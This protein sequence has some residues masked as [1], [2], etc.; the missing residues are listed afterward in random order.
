MPGGTAIAGHERFKLV[1]RCS[2][3]FALTIALQQTASA[4]ELTEVSCLVPVNAPFGFVS[5]MQDFPSGEILIGGQS[6]LFLG[7]EVN[8]KLTVVPIGNVIMGGLPIPVPNMTGTVF[9]M[10]GVPGGAILIRARAGL[11]LARDTG[12]N[13]TVLP[14]TGSGNDINDLF[15]A[16][17]FPGGGLLIATGH[18]SLTTANKLFL[19]HEVSGELTVVP[20]SGAETGLVRDMRDF[21]G[22]RV[23]IAADNGLFLAGETNGKFTLARAGNVDTGYVAAMHSFS[24]GAVLIQAAKGLFLTRET[25]GKLTVTPAGSVSTGDVDKI[26][27]FSADEAL[28]VAAE[29]FFLVRETNGETTFMHDADADIARG[30]QMHR[31]PGGGVLIQA[32]DDW[33]LAREAGGKFTVTTATGAQTGLVNAMHDFPDGG[34]LIQAEGKWFLARE[35]NDKLTIVPASGVQ[36]DRVSEMQDFPGG[37][38]L[39]GTDNGLFL[40]R[41]TNGNL[42]VATAGDKNI[43]NVRA[44]HD[45][46]GGRVLIASSR[47]LSLTDSTPLSKATVEIRDRRSLNESLIEPKR[48]L[49]LDFTIAHSCAP[50]IDQLGL[51]VRVVAPGGNPP[52]VYAERVER[53]T[54]GDASAEIA[55]TSHFDKPGQWA[56]QVVAQ[57]GGGER[58]VGEPQTLTFVSGSW[59]ERWWKVS[60]AGLGVILASLN[61]LL[62][63]LARRSAWAWRLATDDAWGTRILRV[64]TLV[65]SHVPIAQLWIIDLY[66]QR[67]RARLR[68]PRPFLPLP[69]TAPDGSLQNSAEASSPPWKGR[70]LWVQGGSGMGKTSLFRDVT[71]SHFREHKTAF[72]AY[73]KWGCVLVAFAARDFATSGEDKDDPAWVVDAVRATLSSEGLTFASQTLLSR[74]LESGTLAVAID[75]LNEVDRTRAVEAFARA[76]SEAP[77]LITSQQPGNE[78]FTTWRLPTDFRDFTADLLRLYL[79]AEQTEV[80][81][82]RITTS[83]LRDAIR[84]GYDVRL[85]L[86]LV[87]LHGDPAELPTDRMGLY[88]A[89]I[90]AGWPNVSDEVRNEQQSLTAAAAWRMVS[91]RKPNEDMRRLRPDV[92]L[93]ASLLIALADVSEK[94]NRSVRLVRRAG[95]DA[96]EFVHDQM[97]AY[98]AARWFA[99]AG[100]SPIELEKMLAGS[101]I[102]TQAPDARRILWGFAAALLDS[103]RLIELLARVE[104]KEEW[105]T[106][107]RA[108]KAEAERRGLPAAHK[109]ELPL[110]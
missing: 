38:V 1:R 75:G 27:D 101:T 48:A 70:R 74:F 32:G 69:L 68:A 81:M 61:L 6:G 62:F 99:Q 55:I 12:G 58:R 65:L 41:E 20:A 83:G 44:M 45:L 5:A 89:V 110:T 66:F 53:I 109:L 28:V 105:D 57:S 2:T 90:Q 106:L 52:G 33:F 30:A 60:G 21:P 64:A 92:D 22:G 8:G 93:P 37:G 42:T 96:F 94:D 72:A 35:T 85:I 100:F 108:L 95:P 59:W 36:T 67:I 15:L 91:E 43:S 103:E 25:N 84:S 78:L 97:H 73:S 86:D 9:D 98:L 50:F 11:F 102:W 18:K 56:F 76:F 10:R 19:V 29:G 88:A 49:F 46:P 71:E 87:R 17:S 7:R 47:G 54:P 77:M 26:Y 104:D 82:R 23:L 24:D 4:Q 80:V 107:R 31:F 40:A 16:H 51:N 39:I 34:V 79:T 3:I 63:G 14:I 13:V